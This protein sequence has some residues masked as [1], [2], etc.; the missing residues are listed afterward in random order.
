MGSPRVG[1]FSMCGPWN[2]AGHGHS[3]YVFMLILG[4]SNVF[5]SMSKVCPPTVH[6]GNL[7]S[8]EIFCWTLSEHT[9]NLDKGCTNVGL[10]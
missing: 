8:G 1:G 2:M 5:L 4:L 3:L 6:S 10:L 9:L 7:S